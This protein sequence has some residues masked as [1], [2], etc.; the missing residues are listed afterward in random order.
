MSCVQVSST[1]HFIMIMCEAGGASATRIVPVSGCV[2][3]NNIPVVDLELQMWS[4]RAFVSY[5]AMVHSA[6]SLQLQRRCFGAS[7]AASDEP[8]SCRVASVYRSLHLMKYA[9][10]PSLVGVPPPAK[11]SCDSGTASIVAACLSM[12]AFVA[13]CILNISFVKQRSGVCSVVCCDVV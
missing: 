10:L 13:K 8:V 1:S 12:S 7:I 4:R 11:T 2:C 6:R 3:V 5:P 9:Y